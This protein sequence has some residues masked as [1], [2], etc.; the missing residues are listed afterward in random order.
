MPPCGSVQ[1]RARPGYHLN[2]HDAQIIGAEIIRQKQDKPWIR[3]EEFLESQR[4]PSA[5]A[6]LYFEWDDAKAAHQ[7]RLYQAR[8]LL[9][10]IEVVYQDTDGETHVERL[11]WNLDVGVRDNGIAVNE[12][13]YVPYT[14]LEEVS[15]F[16][17]QI[18]DQAERELVSWLHRYGAHLEQ[19]PTHLREVACAISELLSPV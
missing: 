2:N 8:H 1:Y 12:P 19:F 18:A 16:R 15:D 10:A 4:D 17:E 9:R 14:H 13:A 5:P 6:H 11:T 7:H 3:T